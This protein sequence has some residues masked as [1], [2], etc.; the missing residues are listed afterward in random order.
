MPEKMISRDND[1]F[2]NVNVC[3]C[4]SYAKI[5]IKKCSYTTEEQNFPKHTYFE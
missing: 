1:T 3:M 5:Y 4:V 2:L